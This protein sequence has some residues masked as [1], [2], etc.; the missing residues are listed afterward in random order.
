MVNEASLMGKVHTGSSP[1][2]LRSDLFDVRDS[3]S[4]DYISLLRFSVSLIQSFP[5]GRRKGNQRWQMVDDKQV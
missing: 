3:Q 4:H 1:P 2:S 5:A